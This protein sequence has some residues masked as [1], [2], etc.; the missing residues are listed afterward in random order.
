ME[1]YGQI[2]KQLRYETKMTQEQFAQMFGV[3]RATVNHWESGLRS[4]KKDVMKKICDKFD[5]DISYLMGFSTNRHS[6]SEGI[7]IPIYFEGK[8]TDESITLPKSMLPNDANY[9]AKKVSNV[10]NIVIYNLATN[11][12]VMMLSTCV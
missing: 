11:T 4:P 10:A 2:I 9:L 7:S 8:L 1:D 5:I 12:P 3:T 6:F